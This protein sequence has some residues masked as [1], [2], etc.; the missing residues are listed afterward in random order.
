MSIFEFAQNLY[1]GADIMQ[2]RFSK[3]PPTVVVPGTLIE[4]FNYSDGA[5]WGPNF[6]L[7]VNTP[8]LKNGAA[9]AG[10]LPPNSGAVQYWGTYIG[11]TISKDDCYISMRAQQPNFGNGNNTSTDMRTGI[12]LRATNTHGSGT[13]VGI[14]LT[15]G[16]G[17]KIVSYNGGTETVRASS[18]QNIHH[19]ALVEFRAVGNVYT[20]YLDGATTPF[21]TWNDSANL[22]IRGTN[23]RKFQML[24][25]VNYPFLQRHW[26]SVAVNDIVI[27][28]A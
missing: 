12:F 23:N 6:R 20:G 4:P 15:T 24:Q 8:Q 11:G 26:A 17:C 7:D 9:Q 5:G 1:R 14:T 18:A 21:I 19:N 22:A 10:N 16:N 25:E 13:K 3:Q 2:R 27:G 28:E